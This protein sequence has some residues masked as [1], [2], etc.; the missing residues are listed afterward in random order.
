MPFLFAL[1]RGGI[2]SRAI[3]FNKNQQTLSTAQQKFMQRG[4]HSS[5]TERDTQEIWSGQ[6]TVTQQVLAQADIKAGN[7]AAIGTDAP[8]R[9]KNWSV[10]RP[11]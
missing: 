9:A 5:R 8:Q 1:D 6:L 4:P 3:V 11:Q 7:I 10:D 2:S